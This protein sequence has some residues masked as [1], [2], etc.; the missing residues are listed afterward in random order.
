MTVPDAVKGQI[1]LAFQDLA[2][3][4]DSLRDIAS[5][6][7]EPQSAFALDQMEAD[8]IS[9]WSRDGDAQWQ[10][11]ELWTIV[12]EGKY[13]ASQRRGSRHVVGYIDGTW[14]VRPIGGRSTRE[15]QNRVLEFYGIASTRVR[16]F[17]AGDRTKQIAMWRMELGDAHSPGCHF[18]IQILGEDEDGLFPKSLSIPRL[19]NVF[20][21][22]MGV[23][24]FVLGELFQEEWARAA[25]EETGSVLRWSGLQK[26]RLVRLLDWQKRTVNGSLTSPWLALKREKPE[27]R[28]FLR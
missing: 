28:M 2:H 9:I 6:F 10:L 11:G 17:D 4:I 23:V 3:E 16:L 26:T 12:S 14:E 19:P 18:H 21:T 20:V 27:G 13:E 8:L 25:M 5:P 1:R 15:R 24:E 22:P 7:L